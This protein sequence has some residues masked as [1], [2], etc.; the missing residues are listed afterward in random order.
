MGKIL[1]DERLRQKLVDRLPQRIAPDRPR[2]GRTPITQW[3]GVVSSMR[4]ARDDRSGQGDG[5]DLTEPMP[6][7]GLL[8]LSECAVTS[9]AVPC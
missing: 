4:A 2:M 7:F 9:K 6:H 5:I 3:P 8:A 1:V